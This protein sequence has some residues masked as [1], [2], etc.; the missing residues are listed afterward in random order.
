MQEVLIKHGVYGHGN[1]Q[2]VITNKVFPLVKPF[3][4]NAS[5][6]KYVTVVGSKAEGL[7]DRNCRIKVE[8][9]SCVEYIGGN[10][11]ANPAQA[12]AIQPSAE[13][14]YTSSETDEEAMERIASTFEMLNEM[15]DATTAG[16]VRGMVISGPPGIG[17]SY[18][19]EQTLR[20]A[21]EETGRD[22]FEVVKG[23]SSAIGLYKKLYANRKAGFVTVFDDCDS[24]L[25]DEQSL[26]LLKA[27]LDSGSIRRLSWLG[28]SRVLK[29]EDIPDS[30]EFEGSIIFLTNLDF[31]RT[32]A[33][34][35][36]AHLEAIMSR[37]HYINMEISSLRDQLL[38]I[39]QVISCGMLDNHDLTENDKEDIVNFVFDNAEYL[40]EVSL[41]MVVKLADLAEA[42][43]KGSL[44]RPWQELAVMTCLRRDA[45][46]KKL[47]EKKQCS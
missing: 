44:Q 20:Q 43:R 5:G 28:E 45:K 17:K 1:N 41:R 38:R 7:E 36:K 4:I 40:N 15:T 26:N 8:D 35:V 21:A 11:V 25:F 30:F 29:A 23:S 18:G 22:L 9:E 33:T 6:L 14:E 12:A 46:F 19:V 3:T 42:G 47:L 24:I 13:T 10:P 37:C 2:R 34:K 39:K 31:E 32:S 27:A 16:I